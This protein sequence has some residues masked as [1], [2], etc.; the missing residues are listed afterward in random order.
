MWTVARAYATDADGAVVKQNGSELADLRALYEQNADFVR[1]AVIRLGGPHAEV[2]DL[3]H[4]IFLVVLKRGYRIS[5]AAKPTTL[6]YSIAIR[7]VSA[8]RRR[9]KVRQFLG[10]D[11]AP[12][13]VDRTTPGQLF[14]NRE[15]S[16]ALFRALEKIGEKKRTVFVLYELEELSGDEIAEAVGCPIKTVWTRLFHARKEFAAEITKLKSVEQRETTPAR[17]PS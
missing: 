11:E 14:E 9:A 8:A 5:G 12:E 2:D 15:Q 13:A 6:L 17:R 7:V 16:A 1:R 3:V 4:D 10:L